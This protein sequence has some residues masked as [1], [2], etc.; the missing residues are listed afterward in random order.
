MLARSTTLACQ[1]IYIEAAMGIALTEMQVVV[2][3]L[4]TIDNRLLAI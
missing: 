1:N 3:T 2:N 4:E